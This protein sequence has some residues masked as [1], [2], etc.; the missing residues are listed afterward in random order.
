MWIFSTVL[1]RFNNPL[2]GAHSIIRLLESRSSITEKR[3]SSTTASPNEVSSIFDDVVMS[4]RFSKNFDKE[5]SIDPDLIEKLLKLSQTAPSSFNLQP[6]KIIVVQR[7]SEKEALAD[8]MLGGN[9]QRV[10]D[11]P[12]TLVYLSDRGSQKPTTS[13]MT[14]KQQF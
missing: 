13:N 10:R 12:L 4:R 2:R 5:R 8:T 14:S 7:E 1:Y 6:Y 11:A 9:P 3:M